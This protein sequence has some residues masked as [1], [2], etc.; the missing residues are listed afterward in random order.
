MKSMK[1]YLF[2]DSG[3]ANSVLLADTLSGLVG[4]D[5]T[6]LVM[7]RDLT[8]YR[9]WQTEYFRVLLLDGFL[10]A[11]RLFKLWRLVKKQH[12]N[13]L[14]LLEVPEKLK[15]TK[16]AKR[17]GLEVIWLEAPSNPM[18]LN[19]RLRAQL[20]H[21]VG[22]AT[23]VCLTGGVK[24]DRLAAGWPEARL[25]TLPLGL[26]RVEMARDVTPSFPW[27]S[28]PS[29]LKPDLTIGTAVDLSEVQKI[30]ELLRL[31][32]SADELN[33]RIQLVVIGD[34]GEKGKLAWLAKKMDIESHVWLV[35]ERNCLDK[36]YNFFDL[37]IISSRLAD[38]EDLRVALGA[39]A[40]GV[41]VL[42][43]ESEA[44]T[45]C[46]IAGETG[47]FVDLSKTDELA[48]LLKALHQDQAKLKAM[49]ESGRKMI[50]RYFS[51][52]GRLAEWERFIK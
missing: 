11:S 9:R 35:G 17:L 34:G 52:Q 49:G 5:L 47:E 50:A 16:I 26:K 4:A 1:K 43:S 39:L 14:I 51:Y 42:A 19:I 28:R 46:L 25:L 44:M 15:L 36:W 40:A 7:A 13:K 3:S 24:E 10:G 37:L 8:F 27:Q 48:A 12:I 2:I 31:V 20:D 45:D 32:K 29:S 23:V 41:P 38:A 33:L 6:I 30:E 22:L 21:L 18:A